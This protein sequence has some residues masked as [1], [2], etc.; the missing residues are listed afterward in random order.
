MTTGLP[1][2][3]RGVVW[4]GQTCNLRCHFCY[5][6]NRIK[7]VHHPDHPFMSLA[8]ATTICSGLRE[9][10]GNTAVD[11]QGGEPTIYPDILELVAHC[12][13]IGLAP[14]LITNA[15]ALQ[16][17]A[18]CQALLEAGVE[19]LLVSVHGLG[20]VYDT[21]VG[22]AG[23]SPKQ[24]RAIGHCRDLG[25]PL[26][27]NTVLA[28]S[29][30]PQLPDIVRLAL[31]MGVGVVNFLAFNPFEDQQ[32]AERSP[33]DVPRYAE[34]AGPLRAALDL[35]RADDIEANV[36]YLP[37][38]ILPEPY[39]EHFYNFQQLPYDAHEWDYASWSWTAQN[40]QHRRD[41]ELTPFVSLREANRKAHMFQSATDYLTDPAIS[42]EDEYRHSAWIRA[43]EHCGYQYAP[44]CADCALAAVCDG[45]H[46]DY[47]SLF[48][49]DEAT[50]VPGAPVD[51]PCYAIRRQHKSG[52]DAGQV[53]R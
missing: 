10:Y 50:A 38:C 30:L 46:G 9:H 18:R 7:D 19:D 31:T 39:R 12:R 17:R 44:A 49:L 14:T 34:V 22:V 8:K 53:A 25:I 11:I 42:R 37:L 33:T 3:K 47:A 6:Q 5:F 20:A 41:G 40:P 26:R 1:I 51:D 29:V 52:A 32:T 21:A 2:T 16:D 45:F 48:G 23:A 13:S 4:L 36:R 27:F 28:K 15:L 43:R 35:C 24:L